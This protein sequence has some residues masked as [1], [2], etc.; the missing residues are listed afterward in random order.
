M[1]KQGLD[2]RAVT[3]RARRADLPRVGDRLHARVAGPAAGRLPGAAAHEDPQGRDRH[4]GAPGRQHA[5]LRLG[6]RQARDGDA[7]GHGG[8]AARRRL[9]RALPEGDARVHGAPR[10]A[11]RH[12]GAADAD[13]LL[14][15]A[16]RRGGLDR[17]R[18]GQDADRE[19]ALDR[20]DRAG[21][22]ARADVRD[23]RP[24][25]PDARR[26]RRRQGD[27]ARSGGAR[28]ASRA[29]SARRCRGG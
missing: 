12:L 8:R 25:A 17:H 7:R 1:V 21:R 10:A 22:R 29:R 6:G 4:R 19:A 11:R 15:P 24:V 18:A 20:R 28:P 2:A 3:E 26:R 9:V 14:R 16:R 23:Q 5:A 13:V 27:R